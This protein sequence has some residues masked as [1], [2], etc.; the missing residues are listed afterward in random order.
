MRD[1][2]LKISNAD[3]GF[4]LLA[5]KDED[6]NLPIKKRNEK[7]EELLK[8]DEMRNV[9]EGELLISEFDCFDQFIAIYGKVNNRPTIIV[10][11]IEKRT[12]EKLN[13]P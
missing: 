10:H 3:G 7:W 1:F 8:P 13:L 11:D 9:A 2:F 5:L 4:K 12:F 6:L